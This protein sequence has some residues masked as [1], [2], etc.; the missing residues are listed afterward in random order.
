MV[1][2]IFQATFKIFCKN[3]S[4]AQ[5]FTS[6]SSPHQN[7]IVERYWRTIFD[8]ARA[9]LISSKLPE[10]F[11]VRASDTVVLTIKEIVY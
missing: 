7:G 10:S 8:N 6:P 2:N 5:L 9:I 3:N 11:W 4:I 1:G